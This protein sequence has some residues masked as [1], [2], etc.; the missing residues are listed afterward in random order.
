M[1][2]P[3]CLVSPHHCA[4]CRRLHL[5]YPEL[6]QIRNDQREILKY[7]LKRQEAETVYLPTT[8]VLIRASISAMTLWRCE[9]RGLIQPAKRIGRRKYYREVDVE[10]LRKMYWRNHA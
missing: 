1:K 4:C 7:I 2:S 8:E 3:Y 9:K 10:Q 6:L 5:L